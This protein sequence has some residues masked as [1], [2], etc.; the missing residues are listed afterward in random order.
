MTS[1]PSDRIAA[2]RNGDIR[3]TA[4]RC[5]AKLK[6]VTAYEWAGPCPTCR[7][8]DR[9]AVN[10]KK[11]IF[12]CRSGFG[13][14]V[15]ALVEHVLGVPFAAAVEFLVGPARGD[16]PQPTEPRPRKTNSEQYVVRIVREL[17]PLRGTPGEAYLRHARGIDTAAVGDVLDRT[18]A[19]GWHPAVFFNEPG[20][21]L[22]GQRLGCIIGRM[23]DAATAGPTGAISRTYLDAELRKIAKAK[24]LGSPAGIIRLSREEDV[25]S[26]GL[27]L[28]R[29]D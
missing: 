6:R 16:A 29:G 26:G 10:V 19:I 15:I 9:F 22:H 27:H 23:T 7:G 1:I 20:H 17:V 24:T 13:G 14:N 21:A 2:A 8:V 28:G 25:C 4:L 11:Q 3:E 18:D 12:I 5:G